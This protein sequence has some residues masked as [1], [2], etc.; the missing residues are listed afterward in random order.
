MDDLNQPGETIGSR[1]LSSPHELAKLYVCAND[2]LD[3]VTD[4]STGRTYIDNKGRIFNYTKTV[5]G[6]VHSKYIENLEYRDI[7]S[8]VSLKDCPI[9]FAV[10]RPPNKGERWAEV[11]YLGNYPVGILDL[12][13]EYKTPYK[14][15]V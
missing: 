3:L 9:K 12:S 2:F 14:K 7:A 10:K 1:R 15:K 5:Y 13:N 11:L 8:I 6:K 4:K